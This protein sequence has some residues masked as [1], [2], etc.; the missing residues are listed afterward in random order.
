MDLL[1]LYLFA[2]LSTDLLAAE[3]PRLLEEDMPKA[4]SQWQLIAA[5]WAGVAGVEAMRS[6]G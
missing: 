3:L 4:L 1:W 6:E 5:G 2:L